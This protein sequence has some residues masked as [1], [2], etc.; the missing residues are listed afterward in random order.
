LP[1][2]AQVAGAPDRP[3]A[4][5]SGSEVPISTPLSDSCAVKGGAPKA[6]TRVDTETSQTFSELSLPIRGLVLCSPPQ[7]LALRQR[8]QGLA[9]KMD[10]DCQQL[11]APQRQ[12]LAVCDS[13]LPPVPLREPSWPWH[14][15]GLYCCPYLQPKT[16]LR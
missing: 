13:V 11:G 14:S 4:R 6:G 2:A 9:M 1:C 12:G 3:A 15:W 5:T 8:D 10:D 7:G 16:S